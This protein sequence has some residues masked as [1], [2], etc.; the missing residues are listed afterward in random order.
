MV[1]TEKNLKIT[2]GDSFGFNFEIK[3][4]EDTLDSAYFSCKENP[5]DNSYIFQK[6]LGSGITLLSDGSYYVKIEPSDTEALVVT[7]NYYYDLQ[8]QIG[9]DIYT[10][11][12]GKL[13][14]KW[15]ITREV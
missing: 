9:N 11:L 14:I 15:D 3:N 12:K 8:I 1:T 6:S 4:L 7:K 2:R 5:D 10:P 13:E